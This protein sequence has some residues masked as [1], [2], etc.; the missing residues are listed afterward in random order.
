MA[1]IHHDVRHL[2]K[3][4]S[5]SRSSYTIPSDNSQIQNIQQPADSKY[6]GFTY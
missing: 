4:R 1:R 2:H 3:I 6:T 5:Q